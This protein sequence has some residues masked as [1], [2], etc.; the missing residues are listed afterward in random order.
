[1]TLISREDFI[2]ARDKAWARLEQLKIEYKK[3]NVLDLDQFERA[4]REYHLLNASLRLFEIYRQESE[5]R[6]GRWTSGEHFAYHTSA[7][8]LAELAELG[9][10]LYDLKKNHLTNP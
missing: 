1:M 6:L 4:S 5:A 7:T 3:N 2:L 8:I 10:A 9:D